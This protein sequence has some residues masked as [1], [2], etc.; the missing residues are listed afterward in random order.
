MDKHLRPVIDSLEASKKL[1]S[2]EMNFANNL[3]ELTGS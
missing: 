2:E 3:S 1:E